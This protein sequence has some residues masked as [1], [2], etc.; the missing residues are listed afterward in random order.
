MHTDVPPATW[1]AA[2]SR[3]SSVE[4]RVVCVPLPRP[5]AWANVSV[6]AREYLIVTIETAG[7]TQGT[8]FTLGSRFMGGARVIRSVVDEVFAPLLL[9]RDVFEV[10]ALWEEMSF[11]ALLL[12]RRGAVARALSAVDIALWDTMA[13][14][15][16]RPLCDLF[17]RFRTRVPAYASGGYHYSDD[18]DEDLAGLEEEIARHVEMGFRGV[19]IKIGRFSPAQDRR[20][21][22]RVIEVAGPDVKVAVDANNKWR[23]AASAITAL[24]PLDDLSL[25]W[26]EEPVLPD[27]V[28]ASARIATALQTPIAT[29]EIEA[30][31][32]AFAAILDAGAAAILQADV[33]V[34]GG[35]SEWQKVCHMAACRDVAVVPHWVPDLHVHLGAAAPNVLALEY[36]DARVGVL[37]FDALLQEGL[38]IVDGEVLV[39]ERPGHGLLFDPEAVNHYT[40]R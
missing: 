14:S 35:V 11:H 7:G 4:C 24:R 31:R 5:V 33:T 22:E 3:I 28:Q 23:D 8:G 29:G 26:I 21:V 25:W 34:V 39:P 2:E 16:G 10:E 30:G 12:G 38:Q 13:K 15:L 17:G 1:V 37:N 32:W 9:G 36:F 20:R 18:P 40:E 19:K 27:Q 6:D